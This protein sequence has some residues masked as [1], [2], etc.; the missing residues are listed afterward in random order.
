V[1]EDLRV[2]LFLAWRTIQR[3]GRAGLLLNIAIIALVFTNM[4]LLPSIITGAVNVYNEQTMDYQSSDIQITPREDDRYIT[5]ADTLLA[6]VN[7]IPGVHRASARYDLGGT[8]VYNGESVSIPVTAFKPRDEVEVTLIHT[9]VRSGEFLSSGETGEILLGNNVAGSRDGGMDYFDSLG[10]VEVGD[11]ITVHFENGVSR[12]YRVKGIFQT[13]SWAVDYMAFVTWD[14]M[15]Q[16]LGHG[17]TQAAE[18]LVKTDPGENVDDMKMRILS[19][20]VGE[21]VKTWKDV[22]SDLVEESIES[23]NIINQISMLVS[24]II[25]VVVIFVVITIKAV[26]QRREVGILRAI[27]ISRDIIIGSYMAQVLFICLLGTLIGFLISQLLMVYFSVHPLEFPDGNVVPVFEYTTMIEN[28]ALLFAASAIA[29][30]I[31]AWRITRQN[32]LDAIRGPP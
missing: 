8:L 27:G 26:H 22:L 3:G 21:E 16:V 2:A 25:A 15:E 7:R 23:F 1:I 10:G 14:E 4:L 6:K 12:E 18:V 28:T 13:K 19:Y 32:I 17:N 24:L 9:R 11:S 20:G 29:G 5:A 30:Y 31:P